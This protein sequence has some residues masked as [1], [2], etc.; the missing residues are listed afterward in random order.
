M[1]KF[2]IKQS[3][4]SLDQTI[5]AFVFVG[6]S[7]E[8]LSSRSWRLRDKP[9]FFIVHK[10]IDTIFFFDDNHCKESF[11]SERLRLQSPPEER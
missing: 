10:V 4:I 9:H 11:E 8:T 7:D 6:W 3:L 2:W 5:N 1:I